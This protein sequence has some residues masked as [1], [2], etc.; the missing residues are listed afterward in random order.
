MDKLNLLLKK[1]KIEIICINCDN[2]QQKIDKKS[3]KSNNKSA[4]V[5]KP[6]NKRIP[7]LPKFTPIIK[8]GSNI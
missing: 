2:Q 4:K 8:N 5:K 1:Y 3:K 7:N 6:A